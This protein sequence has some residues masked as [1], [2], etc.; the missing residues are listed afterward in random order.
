MTPFAGTGIN[1]DGAT[2]PV[3]LTAFLEEAR[4]SPGARAAKPISRQES[5]RGDY[6]SPTRVPLRS[7]EAILGRRDL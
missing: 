4:P 7:G 6:S 2:K 5:P 3:E 1:V